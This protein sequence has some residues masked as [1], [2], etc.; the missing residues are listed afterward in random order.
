MVRVIPIVGLFILCGLV[1]MTVAEE[2][3]SSEA[4]AKEEAMP[5]ADEGTV[6]YRSDFS[7]TLPKGLPAGWE[8][9]APR[10]EIAPRWRVDGS[11]SRS[12]SGYSLRA[13]SNGL[14][15][16]YGML[17][18]TVA[19]IEP[20]AW[21]RLRGYYRAEGR[22][23]LFRLTRR[24]R[25]MSSVLPKAGPKAKTGGAW[26][27][28]EKLQVYARTYWLDAQGQWCWK[29]TLDYFPAV[30]QAGSWRR[31]EG[32][33]L[34]PENAAALKIQL[35]FSWS[36]TGTVWWDDVSLE[37]A[38]AP[39]PQPVTLGAVYLRPRDSTTERN[40]AEY[41][42]MLDE[43]GEAGCD[44]VCL[45]ESI[46]TVGVPGAKPGEVAEPVPGGPSYQKLAEKAREHRMYVVGCFP[47]RE[48]ELVYNTAFL[49]DR[50][51]QFVGKY[52]KTHLPQEEVDN[53]YTPGDEYPV[54]ETDFGTVGMMICWDVS[55]PEPARILTLKGARIILMPIW[56]GLEPLTRARA[57]ENGCFVVQSSYGSPT[58]I[59][60][61]RGKVLATVG[62]DKEVAEK[63]VLI[64]AEVDLSDQYRLR[65]LGHWWMMSRRERRT[66]IFGELV[67]PGVPMMPEAG[68]R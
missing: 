35:V 30:A 28:D 63:G 25:A 32:V 10:G 43:A 41:C 16:C 11:V 42:R 5:E 62:P 29:Q 23:G 47:E 40:L 64:T 45:P 46:T 8:P 14:A 57:V 19:G 17:N 60:D 12:G 51:G 4:L 52:R 22:H 44:V 39:R 15:G 58:C 13:D 34:A 61:P 50:E 55:F 54:F 56:S 49:I 31:V 7:G 3:L 33:C 9:W 67:L 1:S 24:A 68:G 59:I 20:G 37:K 2:G 53:G 36:A 66:D 38:P 18:Y 48:G 26:L 65:G 21:Y 6:V 27:T